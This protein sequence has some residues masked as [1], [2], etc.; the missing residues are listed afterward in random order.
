YQQ[1]LSAES[2]TLHLA[3]YDNGNITPSGESVQLNKQV[4]SENP[5]HLVSVI[6]S[7]SHNIGYLMYNGFYAQYDLA[8][9]DAFAVLQ[10]QNITSLV[11]DLRYNS[12]GS[13]QSATYLA[14]MITGQFTGE[15]FAQEQWNEKLM[16]FFQTQQPENLL[17]RFTSDIDGT[18]INAL[19]LNTV[20]ILTSK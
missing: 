11:L 15:I 16:D 5:V 13:I 19:N 12:G 7:G 9:N 18:P 17:N 10:G 2:Y 20:Y 6:Q 3:D 4:F 14:S 1:L 8:L